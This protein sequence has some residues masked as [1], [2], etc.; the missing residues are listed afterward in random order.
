MVEITF[1]DVEIALKILT[2][3]QR[4]AYKVRRMLRKFGL[5]E[6]TYRV[7]RGMEDIMQMVLETYRAKR[8][9]EEDS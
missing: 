2:E 4:K 6:G 5:S 7:P 3:F 8:E 1:E 9:K